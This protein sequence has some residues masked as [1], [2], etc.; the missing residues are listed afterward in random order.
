MTG[1]TGTIDELALAMAN[2]AIHAALNSTIAD[3]R[4]QTLQ[5]VPAV[6][7][8]LEVVNPFPTPMRMPLPLP[9]DPGAYATAQ[10]LEDR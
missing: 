9:G 5:H 4:V 6:K 3:A 7:A 10:A 2:V 1:E 8:R